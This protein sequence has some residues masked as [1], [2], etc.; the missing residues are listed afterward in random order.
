MLESLEGIK[1]EQS[2][3]LGFQ[4]SK[5]EAKYEVLLAGLWP[6]K[7]LGATELEVYLDSHLVANQVEGSFG[8][9]YPRMVEYLKLASLLQKSFDSIK[10]AKISKGQNSHVDSLATVTS[11]M[12]DSIPWII[13]V[14]V[15][16]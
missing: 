6:T 4:A 15:V 11:S 10:I 5:N 3:R 9:K 7:T 14:E 8:A 13:S 2:L 12:E 1:L 16:N